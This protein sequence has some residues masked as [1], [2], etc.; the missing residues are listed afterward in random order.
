MK[1]GLKEVNV[2]KHKQLHIAIIGS[3]YSRMDQEKFAEDSLQEK[4]E[5]L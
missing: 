2:W 4:F 1:I 3:M 5:E